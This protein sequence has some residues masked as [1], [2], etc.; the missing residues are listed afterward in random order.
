MKSCFA[1]DLIHKASYRIQRL[2]SGYVTEEAFHQVA[3]Q[4][5]EEMERL[6][7]YVRRRVFKA[8]PELA[9]EDEQ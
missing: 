6:Q 7:Y 8:I 5:A 2:V 1:E 9:E 4:I 3:P